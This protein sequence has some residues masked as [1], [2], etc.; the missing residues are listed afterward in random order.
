MTQTPESPGTTDLQGAAERLAARP[1]S[2][3]AMLLEQT[4]TSGPREA[5][6]YR[7]GD[8]WVSLTWDDLKDRT[9]RLAAGLLALGIQPEERVAIASSTRME[10][11]LADL[12][13]TCA[14]GATT[15][16]YPTTQHEDVAYIV[17]DSDSKI[18]FCEDDIQ[19]SKVLDHLDRL[20]MLRQI[21]I[22]SGHVDHE[23]VLDLV[24]FE[25]LGRDYLAANPDCVEEAIAKTGP[26]S[27]STL[28]YTSGT[29]GRPKGVRLAHD[30]WTYTGAAIEE[31]KLLDRDDV[32][33]LWLPLS[34]VF[35]KVLTAVQL[36]IGF[37]T[38]V[39]GNI[40]RIVDNLGQVHPTFMAGA[41]RIFEKVRA[42][43]IRGAEGGVKGRI[44]DWAFGVGRR[45]IAVRQTGGHASGLLGLQYKLA[46]RL[47]FSKLKERMGGRIKFFVSGSAALNREVQ[48]WFYAAGL[49]ILEGYGLTETSAAT[50][51]NIPQ[52]PR[53][54]TVGPP[55]PGTE[56][57][58]GP[59]G[60][61][62]VRGPGVMQGYHHQ[63]E[64]TEQAFIDGWFATGDIGELDDHGYLRITD[65]KKDL[66]KTSGGKYVAPQKVEGVLKAASPYVSQILVHGEGRKYVSALIA[67]D[68]EAITEW[69][70]ANGHDTASYAEFVGS[71]AVR[72]LVESHV[73]QANNRLERWETIKRFEILP[74][75]LSIEEG[76]V[77][78]S[79]KI[80]RRQVEN[81]YQDVLNSLYT[82]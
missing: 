5:Y 14:G 49:L 18:I 10:W 74:S 8:R 46:D 65:R 66:I 48:E 56:V 27:L 21:V 67:L 7:E 78:P 32:Q 4:K 59:D 25:N 35:G 39:D 12:A 34:H 81:R 20:P 26:D 38:A 37:A 9:F 40:E 24:Q 45:T 77:T 17:G 51:I 6:R 64:A 43:V 57:S 15:T 68:P 54:G 69:G 63:R 30:A 58:F 31:L 23:R 53:F 2:V 55:V 1:P 16:V 50:F 19:V 29:T 76:E 71:A 44:F 42:K 62:L 13:V 11:I 70:T 80:R 3:G 22:L 36:R 82:E 72:Q 73:M 79:L 61:I 75:E 60:E 52:A 41:P 47:V 33:Y 28:I